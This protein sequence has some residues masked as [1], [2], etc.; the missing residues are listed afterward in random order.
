MQPKQREQYYQCLAKVKRGD[1]C[2]IYTNLFLEP[3]I[4]ETPTTAKAEVLG[5]YT[6][7]RSKTL[8]VVVHPSYPSTGPNMRHLTCDP[9]FVLIK[10]I[11]KK[12]Q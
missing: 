9:A 10:C 5:T 2:E 7:T 11:I 3:Q 8:P 6:T 1:I 12:S 4:K